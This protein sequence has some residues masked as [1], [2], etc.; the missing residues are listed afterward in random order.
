VI[1]PTAPG[2]E[3]EASVAPLTAAELTPPSVRPYLEPVLPW[4]SA[5]DWHHL[6]RVFNAGLHLAATISEK[7]NQ[8]VL[9]VALLAHDLGGKGQGGSTLVSCG[10]LCAALGPF[11]ARASLADLEAAVVA[12]NEHSWSRGQNPTSL[13][14]AIL[15]DADR[16]DAI[17]AIGVARCLAYGGA[18]GTPIRDPAGVD[19]V[20][21]FH[22]KLLRIRDRLNLE[23]S[24]KLARRRHDFLVCFLA[25]LEH[26]CGQFEPLA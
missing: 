1:D 7:V 4:D 23:A 15:Q 11:G 17:G 16:L 12:I 14:S 13:E 25:E 5:H 3:P 2:V 8:L 6:V 24:R 22:E 21:H 18:H 26:D 20:R 19:C 10:Q 9:R